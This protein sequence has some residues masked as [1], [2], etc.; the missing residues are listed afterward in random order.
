MTGYDGG[1]YSGSGSGGG[2]TNG[3]GS[4]SSGGG[5][6][7]SSGGVSEPDGG[8]V[9]L[10]PDGPGCVGEGCGGCGFDPNCQDGQQDYGGCGCT[11][12]GGG[13]EA[14]PTQ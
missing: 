6:N 7:S 14:G 11:G 5:S 3:G 10:V 13:F 8:T 1:C 4:N 12:G 2:G 9:A